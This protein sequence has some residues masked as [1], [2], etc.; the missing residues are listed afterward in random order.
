MEKMIKCIH[1]PAYV[2]F[3]GKR[4]DAIGYCTDWERKV[5]DSQCGCQQDK[6]NNTVVMWNF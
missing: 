1:C 6:K 3:H 4:K 2:S 5:T